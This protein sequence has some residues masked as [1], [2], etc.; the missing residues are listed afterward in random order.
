MNLVKAF[1]ERMNYFRMPKTWSSELGEAFKVSD[2]LIMCIADKIILYVVSD[3]L[4]SED[5][6]TTIREGLLYLFPSL[7]KDNLFVIS[8]RDCLIL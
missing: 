1:A 3:F 4:E 8:E 2:R 6:F 7:V 5:N